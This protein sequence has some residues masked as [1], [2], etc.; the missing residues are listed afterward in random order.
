MDMRVGLWR[1]VSTK[2]L[3]LL[4]CGVGEDSWEYL[5]LQG[6]QPVHPKGDQSWVF[7]G[8]TDVEAKSPIL[9]PPD[10]KSWLIWKDPDAG[11]D[12]GQEEKG[13]TED[14]M[15][16]WHH[17]HNGHGFRWTL[18]VGEGQGG[19]ACCSSWGRKELDTTER[20]NWTELKESII[21]TKDQTLCSVGSEVKA[22]ACNAGDLG[23]IPGSG[24]SPGEGNGNPLQYSC[25][26]NPMGGGAGWATVH[27]VTR[28]CKESDTTEWLD[29]HFPQS[30]SY[31]RWNEIVGN[32]LSHYLENPEIVSYI[33]NS[34]D[35][36]S[37]HVYLVKNIFPSGITLCLLKSFTI[38]FISMGYVQ[39][40]L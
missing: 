30:R 21:N 6:V 14:D 26:E 32:F 20:L 33:L 18:G 9:W 4:N 3:M 25:L 19:L 40:A 17:W 31:L 12:W 35:F 37:A 15:V 34:S 2:E 24:R 5:G 39:K 7:I 10:A 16:G 36:G 23:S 8:R 1:K 28:G 38:R 13:T 22:S 11:K 27:R 29:F